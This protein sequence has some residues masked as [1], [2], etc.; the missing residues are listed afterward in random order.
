MSIT[1]EYQLVQPTDN[2]ELCISSDLGHT[3]S[4]I[5]SHPAKN[6]VVSVSNTL[7]IPEYIAQLNSPH[8]TDTPTFR[9]GPINATA[10]EI[11]EPIAMTDE[12]WLTFTEHLE[13]DALDAAEY[14]A[15]LITQNDADPK[16]PCQGPLDYAAKNRVAVDAECLMRTTNQKDANKKSMR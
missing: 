15:T 16:Q 4:Y 1:K 8:I 3:E 11:S 13:H 12:Q 6:L 5:I 14:I 2:S 7:L 10:D 9:H